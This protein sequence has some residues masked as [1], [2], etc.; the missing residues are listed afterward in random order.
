MNNVQCRY[1]TIKT[2]KCKWN[3]DSRIF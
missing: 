3:N 2:W 1:S